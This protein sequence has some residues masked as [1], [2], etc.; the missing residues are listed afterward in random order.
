MTGENTWDNS[1]RTASGWVKGFHG[2]VLDPATIAGAPGSLREL[3][4]SP[5]S[6]GFGRIA[7]LTQLPLD[8]VRTVPSSAGGA[9]HVSN[10]KAAT[11]RRDR[12]APPAP[13][14][15]AASPTAPPGTGAPGNWA[16]AGPEPSQES[17]A[18]FIDRRLAEATFLYLPNRGRGYAFAKRVLDLVGAVVLLV[19]AAP[20]MLVLAALIRLDS[21]GPAIFRQ[22]RVTR[23]GKM[24]TFWK[25]RT[26]YVDARDRFP[27]L[28]RYDV[29][30]E[31]G[32]HTY[33]KLADDPRNTRVGRWLRRSTLDEL[34]N[35]FNV[36]AG[37][38][39]LVGPRP[40]LPELIQLYR[41][42]ELA[43]LFTKA[44]LT[45]LAQVA[46]RS[47]LTVR[48]RLTIDTRYVAQQTLLLDLR[49]LWRTVIIVLI[50]RGAF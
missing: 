8:T 32:D 4:L 27:E 2:A 24:F 50:G 36:L 1:D 47:L 21:P 38:L 16:A 35:L 48:E 9:I 49:I 15:P 26:M 39:S 44:G 31:V 29:G 41:P 6:M 40:D 43:C 7:L 20:V 23:G 45:G 5:R 25:F 13:A 19:L 28:Y 11:A 34:P 46:G 33:Y 3:A 17:L 37:D 42:E 10:G 14:D 30:D 12:P 18:H 22:T